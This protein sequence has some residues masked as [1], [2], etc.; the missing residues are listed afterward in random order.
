MSFQPDALFGQRPHEDAASS[1]QEADNTDQEPPRYTRET[2]GERPQ[3]DW[4]QIDV[5][6]QQIRDEMSFFPGGV[7]IH[8][9]LDKYVKNSDYAPNSDAEELLRAIAAISREETREK[10]QNAVITFFDTIH[11]LAPQD[12]YFLDKPVVLDK[13]RP[14]SSE[15]KQAA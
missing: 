3:S 8:A 5:F 11:M 14:D 10:L 9:A 2:M 12:L 4:E 7:T 15:K 13:Y 6:L 1:R